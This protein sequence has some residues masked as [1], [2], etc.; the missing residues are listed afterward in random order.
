M[1]HLNQVFLAV[2]L[3]S[4]AAISASVSS[5]DETTIIFGISLAINASPLES[6]AVVQ[7]DTLHGFQLWKDWW[8][9]LPRGNRTT[10]WGETINVA[11]HVEPFSNYT[12]DDANMY[13]LFD[14]YENMTKNASIN[15]F[16]APVGSPW[17]VPLRNYT[18]L[19]LS[20]DFM[21]GT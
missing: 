9:G 5:N 16:M 13:M 14:T 6:F 10:K 11:L 8:N 3:C 7:N 12:Y 20:I 19:N 1:R 2:C 18:Y 4:V 21:V 15:Y 17:A